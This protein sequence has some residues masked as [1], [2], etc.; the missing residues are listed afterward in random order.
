MQQCATHAG[1]HERRICPTQSLPILC[2]RINAGIA[3]DEH[4][5][6]QMLPGNVQNVRHD[7]GHRVAHRQVV[8]P[9]LGQF[10][11]QMIILVEHR[12]GER[13]FA[14]VKAKIAAI[15]RHQI[16]NPAGNVR[17]PPLL[18]AGHVASKDDSMGLRGFP[19]LRQQST[20]P[21]TT[22]VSIPVAI[23]ADVVGIESAV[24][25][26]MNNAITSITGIVGDGCAV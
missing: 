5:V 10:G 11:E 26:G 4:G 2:R 6:Q 3:V 19:N 23:I 25:I 24:D 1:C 7:K 8:Q 15:S 21:D 18:E 13:S 9:M 14:A 22:N 20:E 16:A 12:Q 17:K